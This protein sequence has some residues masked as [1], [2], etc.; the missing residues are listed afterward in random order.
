ML[1]VVNVLYYFAASRSPRGT[2]GAQQNCGYKVLR[3]EL[4]RGS[5]R[6]RGR[7]RERERKMK[8]NSERERER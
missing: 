5:D 2:C 8:R 4:D 3:R 7:E 1:N 6:E